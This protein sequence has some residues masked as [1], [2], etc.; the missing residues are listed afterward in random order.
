MTRSVTT[1]DDWAARALAASKWLMVQQSAFDPSLAA[2]ME[3]MGKVIAAVAVG[4]GSVELEEPGDLPV[5]AMPTSALAWSMFGLA[6]AAPGTATPKLAAEL[7]RRVDG[8]T[9]GVWATADRGDHLLLVDAAVVGLAALE[10]GDESLARSM[11]RFCRTFAWDQPLDEAAVLI[12]RTPDGK[13]MMGGPR[14]RAHAPD[15]P[16]SALFAASAFLAGWFEEIGDDEDLAA[17]IELHDLGVA[18]G[19][20]VWSSVAGAMAGLAGA[21][22]FRVTGEEPFRSTADRMADALCEMQSADGSWGSNG[23]A[24]PAEV[25]AEVAVVLADM[26]DLVRERAAIDALL[27]SDADP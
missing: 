5:S 2:G 8:A 6:R 12:A 15:Q 11:A 13:L 21:S 14:V 10:A 22:L 26:A 17:S 4:M 20:E 23:A 16:V 1:P 9:G 24:P 27:G 7:H 18:L 3:A 19:D 25:T